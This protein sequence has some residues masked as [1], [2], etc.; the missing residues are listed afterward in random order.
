MISLFFSPSSFS[1]SLF[2]LSPLTLSYLPVSPH[3][4]WWSESRS[5]LLPGKSSAALLPSFCLLTPPLGPRW[6]LYLSIHPSIH[7]S[8]HLLL[9]FY[10]SPVTWNSPP[11]PLLSCL[12]L[13]LP[14]TSSTRII[15]ACPPL[16]SPQI[17]FSS[18]PHLI[19]LVLFSPR[20]QI[21]GMRSDIVRVWV[22]VCA[23]VWAYG[24]ECE[25]PVDVLLVEVL[26]LLMSL[27]SPAEMTTDTHN[28]LGASVRACARVC[29]CVCVCVCVFIYTGTEHKHW[30]CEVIRA[31][32]TVAGTVFIHAL[33]FPGAKHFTLHS[34]IIFVKRRKCNS[35]NWLG[36]W[37]NQRVEV[38]F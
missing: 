23:C 30:P 16:I 22:C 5:H 21:V 2:S 24:Y 12:P 36:P 4:W 34:H 27:W 1:I 29:V 15:P 10:L 6:Y 20:R 38:T 33:C 11:S 8:I 13:S 3:S 26:L 17:V 18:P 9:H 25:Q 37:T 28:T 31:R 32:Y 14:L 19:F 35:L 7:P